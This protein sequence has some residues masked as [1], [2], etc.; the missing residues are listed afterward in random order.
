MKKITI[1]LLLVVAPFSFA[2]INK[3]DVPKSIDETKYCYYADKEYSKGAEMQ[4]NGKKKRCALIS[5]SKFKY[6]EEQKNNLVWVNI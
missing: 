3:E 1:I 6:Q 5:D 2:D 4:Q